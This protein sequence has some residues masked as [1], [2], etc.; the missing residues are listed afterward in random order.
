MFWSAVTRTS[1]PAVSAAFRR[2]PFS[3]CGCHFNS[4]KVNTS[5]LERKR[6]TPTGTFLSKAMRNAVALGVRQDR[7]NTIQRNLE[8]F[9]DFS[10][11]YAVVEVI[12][13]HADRHPRATQYGGTALDSGFDLDEGAF[14]PVDLVAR[15]HSD[16]PAP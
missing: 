6:R 9:G 2:S 1:K 10:D 13:N 16:L 3:S 5:C 4:S 12:D 8:L 11:T 15:V 14:G 7:L